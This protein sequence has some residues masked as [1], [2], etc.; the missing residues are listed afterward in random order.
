MDTFLHDEKGSVKMHQMNSTPDY[1]PMLTSSEVER[2]TSSQSPQ[3]NV[4]KAIKQWGRIKNV[5]QIRSELNERDSS[6]EGDGT[7]D[8][9]SKKTTI[10]DFQ[11]AAQII[12]QSR[13]A[14]KKSRLRSGKVARLIRRTSSLPM[15]KVEPDMFSDYNIVELHHKIRRQR[16]VKLALVQKKF[17]DELPAL[18]EK[19]VKENLKRRLEVL[20][21]IKNSGLL[22]ERKNSSN[23]E[24]S[25]PGRDQPS[26]LQTRLRRSIDNTNCPVFTDFEPK[27][28]YKDTVQIAFGENN[29]TLSDVEHEIAV[30]KSRNR[31]ES[32]LNLP[33][34]RESRLKTLR[35]NVEQLNSKYLTY[36]RG[37]KGETDRKDIDA[38]VEEAAYYAPSRFTQRGMVSIKNN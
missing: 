22:Y 29:I 13:R 19:S 5:A 24:E 16:Q 4:N 9:S 28:L 15:F 20:E 3:P 31:I 1:I 37:K 36:L 6:E 17:L 18:A 26:R 32:D 11:Q 7:L 25:R 38:L 34:D 21:K 12:I 8:D 2:H 35:L 30:L 27:S 10:S 33:G 23:A 14:A